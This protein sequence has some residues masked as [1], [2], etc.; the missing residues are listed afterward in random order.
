MLAIALILSVS[1]HADTAVSDTLRLPSP[2][3]PLIDASD[4]TVKRRP[5]AIE[6]S[7]WYNRRLVIHKTLAYASLPVFAVQYYAGNKL[8]DQ[9][10]GPAPSWAKPLHKA[11]AATIAGIFTV[12]T[13]T[14][15]WNLWD[16]RNVQDHKW[17]RLAH[18]LTMLGADAAFTYTGI[19]LADDADRDL[20]R[21]RQ[22]RNTALISMGVTVASG[23]S[24]KIFNR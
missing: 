8:Y 19:A 2:A 16:S 22:H 3:A 4:D 23:L 10:G 7:E 13:V 11:G 1:L 20:D 18:S 5:R 12:N 24:M 6:V 14:G 17:L 21:R 15:L 9:S